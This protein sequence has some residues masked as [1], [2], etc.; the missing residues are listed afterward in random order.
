MGALLELNDRT[1]LEQY[2]INRTDID[3]P[4]NTSQNDSIFDYL[5][6]DDGQWGKFINHILFYCHLYSLKTQ[7]AIVDRSS[8]NYCTHT[9]VNK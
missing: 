2:F 5:V 1:K 6:N 3:I 8:K 4:R 9:S 7:Y